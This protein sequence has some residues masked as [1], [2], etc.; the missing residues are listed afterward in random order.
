VEEEEVF[1]G[2]PI[3]YRHDVLGFLAIRLRK[4]GRLLLFN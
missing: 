2:S 3:D 1:L 4:T